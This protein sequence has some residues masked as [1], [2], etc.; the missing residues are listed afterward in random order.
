MQHVGAVLKLACPGPEGRIVSHL[1]RTGGP[2]IRYSVPG[3]DIRERPWPPD[4]TSADYGERCA[5]DEC[6]GRLVGATV[7]ELEYQV[8]K[9][10]SAPTANEDTYPL[11]FLQS[12]VR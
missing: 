1:I 7:D 10:H 4:P 5:C 11:R 3:P 12:R 6:H 8:N 9:L 2:S